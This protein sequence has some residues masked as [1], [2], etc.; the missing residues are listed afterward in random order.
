MKVSKKE[1]DRYLTC[2]LD[3]IMT[4]LKKDG[5]VV[6]QGFGSFVLKEYQPRTAKAPITGVPV[7]LPLRRKAAFHAGKDLRE[8]INDLPERAAPTRP[9]VEEP[10]IQ[11]AVYESQPSL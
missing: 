8:R 1:A 6:V 2:I 7:D 3:A 10:A 4:N 5:R 9:P 11:E